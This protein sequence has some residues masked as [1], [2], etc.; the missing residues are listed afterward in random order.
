MSSC[1]PFLSCPLHLPG[2]G[3]LKSAD[4]CLF[5]SSVSVPSTGQTKAAGHMGISVFQ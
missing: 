5:L 2:V 3:G 1:G 4:A